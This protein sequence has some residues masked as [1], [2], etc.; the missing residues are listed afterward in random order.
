MCC[1]D[2]ADRLSIDYVVIYLAELVE[3]L[4]SP[5]RIAHTPSSLLHATL[6]VSN[7]L[8][9]A[10]NDIADPATNKLL[11]RDAF[12][13]TAQILRR[14]QPTWTSHQVQ[15][16]LSLLDRDRFHDKNLWVARVLGQLA[17][18]ALAFAR[19]IIASDTDVVA[20]L[21]ALVQSDSQGLQL[22]GATAL[23]RLSTGCEPIKRS[24]G[25]CDGVSTLLDIARSDACPLDMK[26]MAVATL[27]NVSTLGADAMRSWQP[28]DDPIEGWTT[29]TFCSTLIAVIRSTRDESEL[30]ASIR[31]DAVGA[32]RN[33]AFRNH[34]GAL[35]VVQAGGIP[36]LMSLL[37]KGTEAEKI[38]AA[39]ALWNVI[40]SSKSL[41][42]AI[43]PPV[44]TALAQLLQRLE[45]SP[46]SSS[47]LREQ[48]VGALHAAL[49]KTQS[50]AAT[51]A[52]N[53]QDGGGLD[54][55]ELAALLERAAAG[56]ESAAVRT[57]TKEVAHQLVGF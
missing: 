51:V 55:E 49:T 31:A 54:V 29:E 8:A 18:D 12:F 9:L 6:A 43:L 2:P 30:C 1:F 11:N 41:S 17:P 56:S 42:V 33:V 37:V 57:L 24:I 10:G 20:S 23:R 50:A 5:L 52:Y 26:A 16:L 15:D 14:M 25:K 46:E 32:L 45:A 53:D 36:V 27:R 19:S 34:Y 22:A 35:C 3:R 13:V 47:A 21:L 44:V 4:D 38:E 48:V 40:A 28:R 7:L 39:G